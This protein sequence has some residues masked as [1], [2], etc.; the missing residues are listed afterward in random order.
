MSA[1]TLTPLRRA[2]LEHLARHGETPWGRMPRKATAANRFTRRH[3]AATNGT[4]RP[5]VE[6][7]WIQ[8][9]YGQRNFREQPDH[10]FTITVEGLE[11][12]KAN[13]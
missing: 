3:A 7:G 11:V 9:R 5:M 6:A 2:W 4:W 1:P 13:A 12:L 10:L 8:A